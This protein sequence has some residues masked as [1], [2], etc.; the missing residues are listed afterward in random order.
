MTRHDSDL[1]IDARFCGPARSANGGY[2]AGALAERL[3][4]R[5]GTVEVMLRHPPPLDTAMSVQH[6]SAEDRSHG[7][8]TAVTVLGFGGAKMAEAR[9]VERELS[10][11]DAV[12]PAVAAAAMSRFGGLRN[13][14]FPTCFACGTDRAEGDGLRIFPG[15]P[16]DGPDGTVAAS[17]VPHP[18]LAESGDVV[19][20]GIERVGTA[21]TW[22][23][24]DC[25]G[26]WSED[27]AGRPVVLGQMTA[28]VDAL[29]VVGE[30][31]VVTGRYLAREGRKSFTASTLYDADGRV[32]AAA[33]HIWIA[34]DPSAF[35]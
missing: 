19:D 9:V 24:L 23:A 21:T 6:V 16:A 14:P 18:G 34:I 33:E 25:V 29:P 22:A 20:L 4:G 5:H 1:T 17:W 27:T 3:V 30:T 13:H 10:T 7:G 2:A 32:V 26:G 15:P 31:H 8:D 28:R 35:R 12:A 11:V